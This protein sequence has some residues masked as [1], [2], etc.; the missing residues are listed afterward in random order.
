MKHIEKYELDELAGFTGCFINVNGVKLHYVIGGNGP[1]LMLL[2]GWPYTWREWKNILP[3]LK[4][5]GYTVIVPDMRGC[6]KSGR[7]DQSYTKMDV[8][9]DLNE[10]TN[11]LGIESIYLMGV[12][13]GMMVAYAFASNYPGKVKKVIL[14]EGA[15]PGFGLE[16]LMDPASGGSWHFGFQMQA[17]FASKVIAG[18]EEAYYQNFW[19]LMSPV[20]GVSKESVEQYLIYYGDTKGSRGGFFHYESLLE[21]AGFNRKNPGKKLQ[22]PVMVINGDQGIPQSVTIHSIRQVSDQF[23]T[24]LIKNCGHTLAEENPEEIIKYILTFTKR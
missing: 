11:A 13:I 18:N 17:D 1:A 6:G 5:A 12:D 19:N 23:E 2:H 4:Q 21:D 20:K 10:L 3:G 14:G 24:A 8:A 7:P 9:S 16:D 15:L 22:M